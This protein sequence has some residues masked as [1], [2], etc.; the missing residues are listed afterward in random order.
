MKDEEFDLR[1]HGKKKP[2]RGLSRWG[3]KL[4]DKLIMLGLLPAL[5]MAGIVGFQNGFGYH[6]QL[7]C[8][9]IQCTNPFYVCQYAE[10]GMIYSNCLTSDK[11]VP[12][13]FKQYTSQQY[14]PMG[15]RLGNPEPELLKKAY[16]WVW[17][18]PLIMLVLNHFL[19]NRRWR[20]KDGK[21]EG[22]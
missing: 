22:K 7:E 18:G 20:P 11:G 8:K 3:Y 6:Y 5:V 1:S 17:L 12:K 9:D 4:N 19:Y 15:T 16:L 21:K 13:E 2:W 14:F 10:Q